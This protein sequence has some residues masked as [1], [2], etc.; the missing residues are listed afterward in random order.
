[1]WPAHTQVVSGP[2][3]TVSFGRVVSFVIVSRDLD[4]A[5]ALS[6]ALSAISD[7][8]ARGLGQDLANYLPALCSVSAAL[9]RGASALYL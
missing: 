2:P 7:S 8:L 4:T 6:E 1:M 9:V 5:T 3:L